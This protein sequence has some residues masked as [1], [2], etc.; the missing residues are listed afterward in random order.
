MMSGNSLKN[1][2]AQLP[3]A[4]IFTDEVHNLRQDAIFFNTFPQICLM[5]ESADSRQSLMVSN[6]TPLG[7]VMAAGAVLR[8]S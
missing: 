6:V 3:S 7:Q 2:Q 1:F 8:E 4:N 5:G